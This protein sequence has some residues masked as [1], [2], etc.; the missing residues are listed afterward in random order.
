MR[1][2]ALF[3]CIDIFKNR[4]LML[5]NKCAGA[6]SLEELVN[7]QNNSIYAYAK[8]YSIEQSDDKM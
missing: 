5:A 2:Q 3:A 4:N 1:R 8:N 7:C 6:K